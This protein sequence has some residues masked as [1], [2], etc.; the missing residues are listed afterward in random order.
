MGEQRVGTVTHYYT[1]LHVAAI[2]LDKGD[3]KVGDTIH[4]KGHTS[5]FIQ[6]VDSLQ[7]E[8]DSVAEAKKGTSVGIKLKEH[9]RE[10]DEVYKVV[11]D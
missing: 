8:H 2:T 3:L 9:G 4:V 1:H 7:I 11:E 10:H 6:K 5:D